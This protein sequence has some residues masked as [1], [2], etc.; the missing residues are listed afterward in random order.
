[1]RFV[2]GRGHDGASSL[3]C[4]IQTRPL[5]LPQLL[6]QFKASAAVSL[7]MPLVIRTFAMRRV[8]SEAL[9]YHQF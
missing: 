6:M 7:P 2:R 4:S 8:R 5:C 1:M 9:E 3:P